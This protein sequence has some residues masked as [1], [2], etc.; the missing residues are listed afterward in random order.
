MSMRVWKWIAVL[1]GTIVAITWG[2]AGVAAQEP[3]GRAL[4]LRHC[5][6]CHGAKGTP[7]QRIISLYPALKTLADSS[8][9]AGRSTDSI[10]AVMRRGIGDMKPFADKLSAEQMLAVAK[11]V[12]TLASPASAP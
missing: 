12:K 11:F 7:S 1:A 8:F 2:A 5:R 10:V 6:T 4:Y 3:D 9:L